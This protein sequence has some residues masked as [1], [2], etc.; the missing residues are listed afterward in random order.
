VGIDLHRRR[1]VV[2]ILDSDGTKV[3]SRRIENSPLELA[4]AVA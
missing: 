4:A 1:S 3:S 2:V